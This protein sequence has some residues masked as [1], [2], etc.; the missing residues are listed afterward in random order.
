[1]TY[2]NKLVTEGLMDPESFTQ[3]DDLARQKLANGKSFVISGNAQVLVNDYRADLAATIPAA[4]LTKIA[5][6]IGPRG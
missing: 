2:L 3:T 1:V 5:L 6:P 4:K